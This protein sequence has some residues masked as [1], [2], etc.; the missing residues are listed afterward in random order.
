VGADRIVHSP[1]ITQALDDLNMPP[2][3]I[4]YIVRI[5]PALSIVLFR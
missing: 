3:N 2:M 4:L 5:G 1:W